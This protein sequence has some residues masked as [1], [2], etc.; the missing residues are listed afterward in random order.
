MNVSK[1]PYSARTDGRRAKLLDIARELYEA[2]VAQDP[3]RTI[4]LHDSTGKVLA[5]HDLRPDEPGI[6]S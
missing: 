1:T 3:D 4:I 5:R 6:A 2:L